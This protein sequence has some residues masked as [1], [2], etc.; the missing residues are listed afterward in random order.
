M[1]HLFHSFASHRYA[2]SVLSANN[3]PP[4]SPDI[5]HV[6][7]HIQSHPITEISIP[8][9]HTQ[10]S[11]DRLYHPFQSDH[12]PK[13]RLFKPMKHQQWIW[14]IDRLRKLYPLYLSTSS[15]FSSS[16]SSSFL[17]TKLCESPHQLSPSKYTY[18]ELNDRINK[19]TI[20]YNDSP[21][22]LNKH[23][24]T[25]SNNST[26]IYTYLSS[27]VT[28]SS[29]F[30][31]YFINPTSYHD[32][33]FSK[34]HFLPSK[35]NPILS[36]ILLSPSSPILPTSS[37]TTAPKMSLSSTSLSSQDDDSYICTKTERQLNLPFGDLIAIVKA[38][39]H[40]RIL[41]QNVNSLEMST[42]QLT[43]E[44]TCDGISSYEIDIGCLTE[45]NTH[46]KHPRGVSTLR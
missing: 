32:Y 44:N 29:S 26:R 4:Q 3:I 8:S 33:T 23:H 25:T 16:S 5:P 27:S 36:P 42:V 45:T 31:L 39:N 37:P 11:P 17:T 38:D 46:W 15:P 6:T 12:L 43:L 14:T 34:D 41:F 24:R 28:S 18:Q 35:P 21:C 19:L 10:H 20:D 40:S 1:T 22:H 30:T 7:I 9:I 2:P 13:Q